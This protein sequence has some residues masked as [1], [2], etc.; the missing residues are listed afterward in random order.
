MSDHVMPTYRRVPLR[1]IR[2]QGSWLET[3]TGTKYLDFG[4]GVAVTTL[5]HAH[6]DLVQALTG[7]AEKL[8]HVSNLYTIPEQ[9][10]LAETLCGHCFAD[11]VFFC[12]SGTEAIE[13]AIKT[14]RKFHATQGAPERHKIITF[15]GAFHGRTLG[16]L[17]AT[18]NAAYLEGFGP[19]LAGFVQI[20]H[21]DIAAVEAAIDDETAAIL[22]EPVQGEGGAVSVGGEFLR[23]LRACADQHDLL[24]IFDEVQCGIGRTGKLFAHQLFD[25]EPDIMAVA[26]GLGGG[27]P[28][29]AFLASDRAAHGM[30]PGTHGST[31]GGNPLACAVGQTVLDHVLAPDFL[32][33]VQKKA[34]FLRQGLASLV[35]RFPHI[36]DEIRG[37]GL[38]IG[39]HCGVENTN[40][41]VALREEKLLAVAAGDNTVRLLPPLTVSY[42]ELT[43]ALRA[44]EQACLSMR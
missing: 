40:L 9:E 13:G 19:P 8:W 3:D 29:G 11:K 24:L 34:S 22:I 18:G 2:G 26:K 36:I 31:Y 25:V 16:A 12:N 15:K 4:S 44:I 1:F 43:I 39:L 42:D 23:A 17:A 6:P 35:D 21:F 28:I 27:F 38:L 10:K 14:A 20:D 37:E 30:L 33:D 7:Q 5:G 32:P 41:V